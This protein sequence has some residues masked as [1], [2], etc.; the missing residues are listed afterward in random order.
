MI[1]FNQIKL[2]REKVCLMKYR[3]KRLRLLPKIFVIPTSI[4][5]KRL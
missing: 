1:L 4:V 2:L 5:G 3:M